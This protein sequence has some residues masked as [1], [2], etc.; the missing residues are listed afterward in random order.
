ME[1]HIYTE[2]GM[3]LIRTEARDP[4]CGEDFCDQCGDCLACYGSDPCIPNDDG[5]HFWV[6]YGD[7]TPTTSPLGG[8]DD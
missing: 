6:Q 5:P 1:M 7:D 8:N 4:E 2:D 3:K